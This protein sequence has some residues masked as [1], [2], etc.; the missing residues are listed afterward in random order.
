MNAVN[1]AELMGLHGENTGK[2]AVLVRR[3]DFR[4]ERKKECRLSMKVNRRHS[5]FELL[6]IK[7]KL[8]VYWKQMTDFMQFSLD[9][10][11]VKSYDYIMYGKRFPKTRVQ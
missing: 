8:R 3:D 10:P 4:N 7:F 5:F 1:L 9:I 2:H 11:V 6:S